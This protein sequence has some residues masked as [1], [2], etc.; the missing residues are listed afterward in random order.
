M[1]LPE[2][3]T[4]IQ[5]ESDRIF[6]LVYGFGHHE[7]K[8]ML[9]GVLQRDET[10][11]AH[12]RLTKALHAAQG[13]NPPWPLD[14]ATVLHYCVTSLAPYE[15]AYETAVLSKTTARS[16]RAWVPNAQ[17]ADLKSAFVGFVGLWSLE[18]PTFSV[19]Q[20]W[21]ITSTD[22]PVK[23]PRVKHAI[24]EAILGAA[25]VI[26][27]SDLTVIESMPK[28]GATTRKDLW[29]SVG[30]PTSLKQES[31]DATLAALRR[32]GVVTPSGENILITNEALPAVRGLVKGVAALK[33]GKGITTYSKTAKRI[34]PQRPND[35]TERFAQIM[36]K[37][38][39]FSR[40]YGSA[41]LK[42]LEQRIMGI[43]TERG[44]T[45]LEECRTILNEGVH[46]FGQ[47]V[48]YHS[49]RA[50]LTGLA[51]RGEINKL[52]YDRT[53]TGGNKYTL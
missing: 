20:V 14:P 19:Q 31:L 29:E 6:N 33:R 28:Q 36:A 13:E 30:G 22:S 27:R 16:T 17:D 53:R 23:Y 5:Y 24:C 37:G 7:A 35:P 10:P 15:I 51:D 32:A 1:G 21:G 4:S 11:H 44:Q 42:A 3:T 8:T 18:N 41:G 47:T 39:Q 40:R 26:G 43:M 46:D 12:T 38:R 2:A 45:T 52:P 34:I 48:G 25:R 50:V 49:V 9:A